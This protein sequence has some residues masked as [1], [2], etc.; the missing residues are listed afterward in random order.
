MNKRMIL[1]GG[2]L[3]FM[4]AIVAGGT[5]AFFSDTETSAGN[6][7][8]AGSIDLMIDHTAQ[9]YNGVSCQTCG[10]EVYSSTDTIVASSSLTAT[11]A[12]SLPKSAELVT[13]LNPAWL[14][15]ST[16]SP[17]QWIWVTP[18]V[19]PG[20]T[21]NNAEYTFVDTFFLQG[22]IS[23]TDIELEIASDNGYKIVINGV[24]IVNELTT[25]GTFTGLNPLT[26]GQKTNFQ[27]ALIQ[28][29]QNSLEITV[30]N[31]AR[32]SGSGPNPAGL[33]YKINFSNQ[34]CEAGV[35]DFQQTCELWESTDLTN[36]SFFNFSDIKPQDEGTNLISMTVESNES[37]VCLDVNNADNIENSY[38]DAEVAAGDTTDDQ[39]EMGEFLQV[40]GWYADGTGDVD[41]LL[42]G[43]IAVNDAGS[44][45]YAD[46][47][48]GNPVQPG[49][50]QYMELAWCMGDM[51]ADDTGYTCDGAVPDINQT[52]TDAFLADLQFF[53]IQ[54]RNNED[55][56]CGMPL[57]GDGDGV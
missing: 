13:T 9:S 27:N 18:T 22:P 31:L 2:M 48:T 17:A 49:E 38:L 54:T 50:T 28:N 32:T 56:T 26:S 51:T 53:A 4:A 3:V 5:G 20:D 19:T 14:N 23:L 7:F 10:V 47:N 6:V 11:E 35:A 42:F 15:P 55:Y 30:R 41:S 21:T 12:G 40:A 34:D 29:G 45:T 25:T 24:E 46:S 57:P 33:I 52:Q 39:G 16:I 36:E 8:T 43:P 1:S 44:I 37:Y